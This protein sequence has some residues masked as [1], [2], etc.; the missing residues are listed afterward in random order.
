LTLLEVSE[1]AALFERNGEQILLFLDGGNRVRSPSDVV[2]G[3]PEGS[4]RVRSRSTAASRSTGLDDGETEEK[5]LRRSFD[6]AVTESRL[7]KEMTVILSETGIG[8]R[9]DEPGLQITHL[10]DG[11]LLSELG[12]LPGDVLLSINEVPLQGMSSLT[13]LIPQLRSEGEIKVVVERRGEV[14]KLAYDIR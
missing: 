3:Q 12:L 11:T 7:S 8:C 6:R 14:L 2:A 10:P 13:G 4:D 1:E 9:D 5:W